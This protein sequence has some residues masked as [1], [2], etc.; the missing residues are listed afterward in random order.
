MALIVLGHLLFFLNLRGLVLNSKLL[1]RS[2]L[3]CDNG[4]LE[5]GGAEDVPPKMLI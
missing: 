4:L 3:E 5:S 2:D 1:G